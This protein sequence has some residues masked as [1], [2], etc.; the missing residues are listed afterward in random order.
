M[1]DTVRCSCIA[2]VMATAACAPGS[3]PNDAGRAADE[4]L[5]GWYTQSSA[6]A[7]FQPCG[8]RESLVVIGDTELRK[9]A[10]AFGLQEGLPVYV[11][12]QGVRAAGE[13][14]PSH[15]EQF[16]SPTPIS[17]CPMTGTTIQ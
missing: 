17:D 13:F 1:L 3:R 7:H 11:R 6:Q 15:I 2:L 10:I 8:D 4:T 12:L 16:G 5:A 14:R 9:R